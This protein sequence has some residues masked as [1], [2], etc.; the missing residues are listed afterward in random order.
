MLDLLILKHLTKKGKIAYYV[1]QVVLFALWAFYLFGIAG[2]SIDQAESPFL[3]GMI[4]LAILW[5]GVCFII[6]KKPKETE[7]TP[8]S[9]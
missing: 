2:Y 6:W 8:V 7:D 5:S 9:D 3:V 1:G 4:V